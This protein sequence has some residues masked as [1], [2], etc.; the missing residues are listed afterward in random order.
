MINDAGKLRI[1]ID[2]IEDKIAKKS[3]EI[4]KCKDETEKIKL[5]EQLEK[6]MNIE[7]QIRA[8]NND[9]IEEIIKRS[10]GN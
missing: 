10:R 7:N 2:Y 4:R 3:I 9:Y 6:M 8:G 1:A 5:R